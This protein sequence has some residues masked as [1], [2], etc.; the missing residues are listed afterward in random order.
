MTPI[1]A[2][3]IINKLNSIVRTKDQNEVG[4]EAIAAAV[5]SSKKPIFRAKRTAIS[6]EDV[7]DQIRRPPEMVDPIVNESIWEEF[8]SDPDSFLG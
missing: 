6:A 2:L 8:E 4:V 1:D 3:S 7:L 5:D